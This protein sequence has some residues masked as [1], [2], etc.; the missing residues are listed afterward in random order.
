M[1]PKSA[2]KTIAL[3]GGGT[4]GH[5]MPHLAMLE[6]FRQAGWRVIYIGSKGIEK[7]L[8]SQ[9]NGV[10][11]HTISSGKLRRYF[12]WENF[13]DLFRVFGGTVQSIILMLRKRPKVIFSK[14][15]FVSVPVAV[16]AWTLRIPVVSHESDLTP[17]LATKIITRFAARIFYSFPE[18][19]KFLPKRKS[20]LVGLPIRADLFSG[21]RLE[22]ARLC[23]FSSDMAN[24]PTILVM[25]GSLGA[26]K[27]NDCLEKCLPDLVKTFKVV[28]ITGKGKGISFVHPHYKAF[29]FVKDEL[30]HLFALTD[31]VIARA[32]AN[33]IFEFLALQKPMLLIPLESGSRGDQI[34][35]AKNFANQGWAEILAEKDLSKD[36]LMQS[37]QNLQNCADEIRE[38]QKRAQVAS[39]REKI[40]YRLKQWM[41]A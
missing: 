26:Q 21:D 34:D 36:T 17:G 27:I 8:M 33:S 20:E 12:S 18:T 11:F 14:G 28:H 32:G 29:E 35:N 22:G 15:G 30:K 13:A 3:T 9:Q 16:A 7:E 25:G 31:L 5:V 23:G 4:A 39:A 1:T 37:V 2:S 10:D 41:D 24:L 40:M 6:D 19:E 38:A